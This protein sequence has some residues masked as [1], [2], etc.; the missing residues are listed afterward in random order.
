MSEQT[1]KRR[2]GRPKKVVQETAV[3]E[4][5]V[6]KAEV[7]PQ[8]PKPSRKPILR[9]TNVDRDVVY[10]IPKLGGIV[11]MIKQKGVTVYDSNTDTVRAMRYCPNEPSI[12]VDEQSDNAKK[13]AVV[14]RDGALT[15][16][17]EK[18]NLRI[19]LEK[20]PDNFANGGKIFKLLDPTT[21]AQKRLEKEFKQSEA[22]SMVRDKDINDLLPVAIYYGINIDRPTADIRYE[23]LNL[24]KKNPK[25]FISSFDSPQVVA[26]SIVKQAADY[27]IIKV[28]ADGV[29]WFDSNGLIVSVPVGA[30][31]DDV[32]TRF[33]LT[34]KGASVLSTLE[35]RLNKLA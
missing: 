9:K 20:H 7:K 21:D 2:A 30:N 32:M 27:Q 16:P 24:A 12:W 17:K 13:E 28:K 19:F 35:E 33:C 4:A 18:P 8:P 26:R 15:V 3:A 11:Y 10:T 5:P 23:L 29:Y 31:P 6:V 22:V 14:F 34:E 25:D 1:T